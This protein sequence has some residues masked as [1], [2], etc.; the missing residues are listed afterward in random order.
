MV[1]RR[2][3][4]SALSTDTGH[5]ERRKNCGVGRTDNRAPVEKKEGSQEAPVTS[6]E[7]GDTLSLAPA[8]PL[9]TIGFQ[10]SK[11]VIAL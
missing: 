9:D 6:M 3:V 7:C 8:S 4:G 10:R 11:V 2:A 5:Q 1:Q